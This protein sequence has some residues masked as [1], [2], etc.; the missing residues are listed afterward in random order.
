MLED[1][2]LLSLPLCGDTLETSINAYFGG[3]PVDFRWDGY[4]VV[5]QVATTAFIPVLYLSVRLSI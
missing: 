4:A 2:Q 1:L 3:G 5:P